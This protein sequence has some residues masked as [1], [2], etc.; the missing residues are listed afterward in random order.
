MGLA[1][2]KTDLNDRERKRLAAAIK[3]TAKYLEKCAA[4]ME[5]GANAQLMIYFVG[6]LN[7][8]SA[9]AEIH[10]VLQQNVSKLAM[11]D[12]PLANF[13]EIINERT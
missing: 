7:N 11:F 6:V 1:D 12:S 13:P 9:L 3:D 10:D 8:L 4:A 5:K 2:F